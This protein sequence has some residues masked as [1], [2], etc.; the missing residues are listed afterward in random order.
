M[1]GRLELG[2]MSSWSSPLARPL[3]RR[4]PAEQ[5]LSSDHAGGST[6]HLCSAGWE[7]RS[8]WAAWLVV[9][10]QQYGTINTVLDILWSTWD[11][12]LLVAERHLWHVSI[13]LHLS[14]IPGGK[15]CLD[16]TGKNQPV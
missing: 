3:P 10:S 4:P 7:A 15:I 13:Q 2:S 9:L 8:G 14:L 5:G 11:C 12:T 16:L 1:E 6:E